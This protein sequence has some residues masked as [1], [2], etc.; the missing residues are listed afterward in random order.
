MQFLQRAVED[1][2]RPAIGAADGECTCDADAGFLASVN[3]PMER[4]GFGMAW[5]PLGVIVAAS[6]LK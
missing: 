2:M 4:L 3:P 5:R 6:G 1:R